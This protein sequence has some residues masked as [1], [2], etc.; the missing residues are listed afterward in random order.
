MMSEKPKRSF[1]ELLIEAARDAAAHASGDSAASSVPRRSL[2]L[3][4]HPDYLKVD[5]ESLVHLDWSEEEGP[6]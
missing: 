3:E 5:P 6:D 1:A 4:P 2:S